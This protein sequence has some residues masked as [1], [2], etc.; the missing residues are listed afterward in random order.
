[1]WVCVVVGLGRTGVSPGVK[2][3]FSTNLTIYRWSRGI[4]VALCLACLEGLPKQKSKRIKSNKNKKY[5]K[6]LSVGIGVNIW[7]SIPLQIKEIENSATFKRNLQKYLQKDFKMWI[8]R[9]PR[10]DT[11]LAEDMFWQGTNQR[12]SNWQVPNSAI[13]FR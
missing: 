13:N 7:N 5:H 9:K 10:R 8:T 1:M 2:L 4:Q 12:P 6:F 3:L 11:V